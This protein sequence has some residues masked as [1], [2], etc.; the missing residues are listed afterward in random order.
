MKLFC[1]IRDRIMKR[2]ATD[3]VDRLMKRGDE[4]SN[5]HGRLL[6]RMG[7][8]SKIQKRSQDEFIDKIPKRYDYRIM[9]R[10]TNSYY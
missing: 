9:K 6:K 10:D 1:N 4:E 7:I 2:I 3:F 5:Y 8:Y